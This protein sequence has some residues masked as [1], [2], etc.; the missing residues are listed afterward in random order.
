MSTETEFEKKLTPEEVLINVLA[1]CG[2][3]KRVVV[4]AETETDFEYWS[5]LETT[6]RTGLIEIARLRQRK[7][8]MDMEDV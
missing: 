2:R 6:E 5:N 7:K 3:I 4:I 8:I 1:D